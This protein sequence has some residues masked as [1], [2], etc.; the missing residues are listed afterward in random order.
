MAIKTAELISYFKDTFNKIIYGICDHNEFGKFYMFC[1]NN[2]KPFPE[3][4]DKW[5]VK[6]VVPEYMNK[7][8]EGKIAYIQL[9]PEKQKRDS[10]TILYNK[11]TIKLGY[12]T[13]RDGICYNIKANEYRNLFYTGKGAFIFRV[14]TPMKKFLDT[15]INLPKP[16]QYEVHYKAP[17]GNSV[18]ILPVKEF[19]E[20]YKYMQLEGNSCQRI[21]SVIPK[22]EPEII[23]EPE[24]PIQKKW[25]VTYDDGN[26]ISNVWVYADNKQDAM[27]EVKSEYHDCKRILSI[28]PLK[29]NKAVFNVETPD[30]LFEGVD[31]SKMNVNDIIKAKKL[32]NYIVESAEIAKKENIELEQV[33]D[34]QV[35]EGLFGSILGGISGAV[36]GPSISKAICHVLGIDEKGLLGSLICSRV[37]LAALGGQLGYKL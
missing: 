8:Y 13:N 34:N 14:T 33:I 29:E 25:K 20:I 35:L 28:T 10:V 12:S 6:Q 22:K 9:V 31:T 30:D 18:T 11:Y 4:S 21:L 1:K 27:A 26:D 32:Y 19:S 7:V 3:T 36:I 23:E 16:Q 5:G 15:I 2:L 37:V 17:F 24:R